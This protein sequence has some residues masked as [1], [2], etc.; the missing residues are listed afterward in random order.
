MIL[1][2]GYL[3]LI[4]AE[5]VFICYSSENNS[6]AELTNELAK[7]N[8]LAYDTTHALKF[9]EYKIK[10]FLFHLAM[11]MK[12]NKIWQGEYDT[13]KQFFSKGDHNEL[14]TYNIYNTKQFE[15]YLFHNTKLE[16]K[17]TANHK[18]G[19]IYKDSIDNCF[20]MKLNLQINL[21]S[22]KNKG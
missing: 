16:T 9:Y 13:S 3:P 7:T 11:G 6:I 4:V 21:T 5:M 14:I 20:Y 8:S 10:A 22:K 1:L 15:D 18:S 19:T 17:N 12:P 2:D